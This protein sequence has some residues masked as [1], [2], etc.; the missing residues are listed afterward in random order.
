MSKQACSPVSDLV[1][2]FYGEPQKPSCF[3]SLHVLIREDA[4]IPHLG[5]EGGVWPGSCAGYWPLS[6]HH[7]LQSRPKALLSKR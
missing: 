6:P 1:L 7:G 5:G 3:G 2:V 4:R